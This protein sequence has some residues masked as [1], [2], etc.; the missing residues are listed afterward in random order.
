ML[1]KNCGDFSLCEPCVIHNFST[2]DAGSV[3]PW[4]ALE[5]E[6]HHFVLK[7]LLFHYCMWP[8]IEM[9]QGNVAVWRDNEGKLGRGMGNKKIEEEEET[10]DEEDQIYSGTLYRLQQK[11][12]SCCFIGCDIYRFN[13]LW[14]GLQ[15]RRPHS[16]ED[17]WY[18]RPCP[19]GA[20]SLDI[21]SVHVKLNS[22]PQKAICKGP[23]YLRF[24]LVGRWVLRNW[25]KNLHGKF[26]FDERCGEYV[27]MCMGRGCCFLDNGDSVS[28]LCLY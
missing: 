8:F 18:E 14:V 12:D 2:W 1:H 27:Y 9:E 24:I 26:D 20:T 19:Y 10:R 16:S 21:T 17:D 7:M 13:I 4:A 5:E 22:L 23:L 11:H 25:A 28:P 6:I 3:F 15:V